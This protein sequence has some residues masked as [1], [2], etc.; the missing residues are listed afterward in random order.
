MDAAGRLARHILKAA[1]GKGTFTL[2]MRKKDL[3]SHLNLTSETLSRTLRRLADEG[4]IE[5]TSQHQLRVLNRDGLSEIA[6]G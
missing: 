2:A 6:E 3:A 4:L 1:T 5:T